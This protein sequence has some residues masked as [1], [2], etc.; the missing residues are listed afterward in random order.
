MFIEALLSKDYNF[1]GNTYFN[2]PKAEDII[3]EIEKEN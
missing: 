3:K 2:L 1:I